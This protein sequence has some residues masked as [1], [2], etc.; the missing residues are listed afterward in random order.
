MRV[1][2]CL[3]AVLF[4]AG[5]YG[6]RGYVVEATDD[7]LLKSGCT[8]QRIGC[9]LCLSDGSGVKVNGL[10]ISDT[11]LRGDLEPQLYEET[12][13]G[14]SANRST[15]VGIQRG[16]QAAGLPGSQPIGTWCDDVAVEQR[17]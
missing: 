11:E 14:F 17:P 15:V 16:G 6:W 12:I 2:I 4:L 7:N 8:D 1:S 3:S 5:C 13:D 10:Q 9:T